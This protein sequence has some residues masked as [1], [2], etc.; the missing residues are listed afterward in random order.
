MRLTALLTQTPLFKKIMSAATPGKRELVT[1]LSGSA[2][3]LFLATALEDLQ[4]PLLVVV[5]TLEHMQEL[6]NDLE[7][8]L[9]DDQVFQ[10]PVEESVAMELA[11]S[12]PNFRLQRVQA[13]HV[14]QTDQPAIIVTATAGLRRKLIAPKDFKKAQLTLKVGG[15]LDPQK[16]AV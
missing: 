10:F 15:E 5:D 3:T 9:P 6:A 1:G 12:S 4:K 7:N 14:L 13:L 11:T 16:T 2:Q 8:L